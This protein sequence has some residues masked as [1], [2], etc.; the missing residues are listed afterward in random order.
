MLKAVR[1]SR[2]VCHNGIGSAVALSIFTI[3][4]GVVKISGRTPLLNVD[5]PSFFLGLILCSAMFAVCWFLLIG[6]EVWLERS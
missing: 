2:K 6:A 4:D 3:V 1:V 5:H